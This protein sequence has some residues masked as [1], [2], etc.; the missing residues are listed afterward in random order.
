MTGFSGMKVGQFKMTVKSMSDG[1]GVLKDAKS[2][3]TKN[4]SELGVDTASLNELGRIGGEIEGMLPEARRRLDLGVA[5]E[6]RKDPWLKNTDAT[7]YVAEPPL[8][9]ADARAKGKEL[10]DRLNALNSSD[11]A[12]A[13][14]IHRIA[15]ELKAYQDDPEVLAAFFTGV[16]PPNR[17]TSL[18]NLMYACG[19]KTATQDL[20]VFSKAL[21]V[22][23]SAE[24][25]T[26]PGMDKVKQ[27]LTTSGGVPG[28]NWD[29]LALL[30]YGKFP[31]DFVK[32]AAK[33]LAL[34]DFAKDPDQDFR[35]GFAS[36]RAYNGA[37]S[38]DNVALALNML[39]KDDVAARDV[40]WNM[41]PGDYRKTFTQLLNYSRMR[42]DV[43]DAL[44]L[45]IE[46]GGGVHT[47]EPGKHS[48]GASQFAFEWILAAGVKGKD[49]NWSLKDSNANLAS[50]YKHELT[51]GARIDDARSRE[52]GMGAPPDFSTIPG[53]T[54]SFYLNPKDTY[55]FIKT[56]ADHEQA[57]QSFDQEM[58][59][60]RHDLLV[61]AAKTDAEA[62]KT[63]K[64]PHNFQRAAGALGDLAG[65]EYAAI[66][67]VRG[68]QDE[69]DAQMRSL[70]KDVVTVGLIDR[71]PMS[72]AVK[73]FGWEATKF[74]VGKG[75]DKWAG[76]DENNTR[77]GK[78]D[79]ATDAWVAAQRYE[80]ASILLE[81][82]YPAD[83]PFP[84]ELTKDGKP[85][86]VDE[87]TKDKDKL[88]TF[89][90]WMDKTD[91]DGDGSTFDQKVEEGNDA[92]TSKEPETVAKEYE[93]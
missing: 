55:N 65:L 39:G 17:L 76:G 69:F 80:M 48:P 30:Q 89:N 34:D 19:S 41:N 23:I 32:L 60:F 66:V 15:E 44:G 93:K 71:I 16:Q 45:A 61:I 7:T 72:G 43:G 27:A 84:Q 79:N 57:T 50:S 2:R 90:D 3:F 21:G 52:S 78:F 68:D 25:L 51:T 81:A 67:K 22:A 88:K 35:G 87:M 13:E 40:L 47:E 1:A 74:M 63:G 5:L 12:S 8:S 18:P 29:K 54:P 59:A 56:F 9:V 10:A 62:L 83:P 6:R 49:V 77:V 58:G 42:D 82:G 46:A 85:L 11:G 14:E 73:T 64:D 20:E 53:L 75:L 28:T 38:E 92:V 24:N 91:M 33:N 37:V 36:S 86:S 4:F 26:T 31:T 70:M